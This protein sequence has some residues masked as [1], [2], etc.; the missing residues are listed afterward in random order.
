MLAIL[1]AQRILFWLLK[2]QTRS[3]CKNGPNPLNHAGIPLPIIPSNSFRLRLL[4]RFCCLPQGIIAAPSRLT[5]HRPRPRTE[6]LSVLLQ[7][8]APPCPYVSCHDSFASSCNFGLVLSCQSGKHRSFQ[9]SSH[10]ICDRRVTQCRNVPIFWSDQLIWKNFQRKHTNM[11]HSTR[12]RSSLEQSMSVVNEHWRF[13]R[14]ST[15]PR[16]RG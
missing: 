13:G 6:P 4:I 11:K 7:L 10:L 15:I 2:E 16:Q 14:Q 9:L 3:W 5:A 8:L 1:G 12:A